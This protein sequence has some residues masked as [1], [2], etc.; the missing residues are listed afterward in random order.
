MERWS[1][2]SDSLISREGD[3]GAELCRISQHVLGQ[4]LG[5]SGRIQLPPQQCSLPFLLVRSSLFSSYRFCRR[6]IRNHSFQRFALEVLSLDGRFFNLLYQNVQIQKNFSNAQRRS[7]WI[8]QENW[9]LNF[10]LLFRGKRGL[11]SK[12]FRLRT[13]LHLASDLSSIFHCISCILRIRSSFFF[14]SLKL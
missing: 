3:G 12:M 11:K 10:I 5:S 14:L 6:L 8:F 7:E 9:N 4:T 1:S 2:E 13:R